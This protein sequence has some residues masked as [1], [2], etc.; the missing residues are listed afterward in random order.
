M[1]HHMHVSIRLSLCGDWAVRRGRWGDW[2]MHDAE[3][4]SSCGVHAD[5]LVL[6]PSSHTGWKELSLEV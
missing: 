4:L 6:K 5:W 2:A 3:W 1:K